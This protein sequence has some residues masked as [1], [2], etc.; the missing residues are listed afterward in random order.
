MSV[1][2]YSKKSPME[3]SVDLLGTRP[4][5]VREESR[6]V[7]SWLS[8]FMDY[9]AG[10]SNVMQLERNNNLAIT[11]TRLRTEWIN[12]TFHTADMHFA[13]FHPAYQKIISMGDPI[14][15]HLIRD[16]ITNETHWFY[17]LNT[18]VGKSVVKEEHLGKVELMIKD[19]VE[20]AA[21][22][23]KL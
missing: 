3:A 11:F 20:W 10:G 5:S 16:M 14:I 22:N 19:W 12:D 9:L 23:N 4:Y 8:G 7:D 1:V 17:A 6:E 15:P 13:F 21:E 18:I 2:N